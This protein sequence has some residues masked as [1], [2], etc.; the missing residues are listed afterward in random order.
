[1]DANIIIAHCF[2]DDHDNQH[3]RVLGC[4][5]R[6]SKS[7]DISLIVSR[8]TIAETRKV[9][10]RNTRIMW[11]E[12][13]IPQREYD[14]LINDATSYIDELL[15]EKK[16]GNVDFELRETRDDISAEELLKE[17]GRKAG[18]GKYADALHCILM[19]IFNIEYILTFDTGD[20]SMFERGMSIIPI[21]P[22]DIEDFIQNVS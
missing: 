1:M 2:Q 8:W 10:I 19:N 3:E 15:I 12:E 4:L 18:W 9:I 22:D 6:I 5:E 20:F 14:G 11:Q 16:I 7:E 13:K 21:N 17:V